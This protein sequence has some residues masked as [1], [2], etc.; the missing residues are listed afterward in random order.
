MAPSSLSSPS[1]ALSSYRP[2]PRSPLTAG[3][4][5]ASGDCCGGRSAPSALTAPLATPRHT[6]RTAAAA[7][8]PLV[9][10]PSLA[11]LLTPAA[12]VSSS[13]LLPPL[14]SSSSR[15]S[16]ISSPLRTDSPAATMGNNI[17]S[18]PPPSAFPPSL[19]LL[20]CAHCSHPLLSAA[21]LLPCACPPTGGYARTTSTSST[22]SKTSWARQPLDP[23]APDCSALPALPSSL[24]PCLTP[25]HLLPTHRHRLSPSDGPHPSPLSICLRSLPPAAP[26]LW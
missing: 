1:P 16:D 15:H 5:V 24:L 7:C 26:S 4:L 21:A 6:V 9:Q 3:L 19:R 10:P 18:T 23:P 25:I 11:R 20:H 8:V 22:T 2:V 12:L 14:C 13:S 17:K